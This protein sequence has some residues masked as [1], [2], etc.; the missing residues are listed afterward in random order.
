MTYIFGTALF[1]LIVIAILWVLFMLKNSD[2]ASQGIINLTAFV[3]VVALMFL[4][5]L[6]CI[7][8]ELC[9]TFL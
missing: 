3:L 4:T 7:V 6:V 5:G 2:R 9:R 1:L 8:V